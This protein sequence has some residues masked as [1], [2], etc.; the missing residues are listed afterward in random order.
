VTKDRRDRLIWCRIYAV[1]NAIIFVV[2]IGTI[3][4]K[5]GAGEKIYYLWLVAGIALT[6]MV[7]YIVRI[8][9]CFNQIGEPIENLRRKDCYPIT[10]IGEYDKIVDIV[11]YD[12]EKNRRLFTQIACEDLPEGRIPDDTKKLIVT[13]WGEKKLK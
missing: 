12:I 10:A 6:A 4:Y 8:L 13:E 1:L 7:Y 2:A 5:I 11:F 3:C 9:K